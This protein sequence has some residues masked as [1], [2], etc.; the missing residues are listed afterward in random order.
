MSI[1]I[2]MSASIAIHRAKHAFLIHHLGTDPLNV[3][4]HRTRDTGHRNN[5]SHWAYVVSQWQMNL[6]SIICWVQSSPCSMFNWN[7]VI[8]DAQSLIEFELSVFFFF[9]PFSD[10]HS[11]VGSRRFSFIGYMHSIILN[12][13]RESDEQKY[14]DCFTS[15]RAIANKIM[16]RKIWKTKLLI[17]QSDVDLD[18]DLA[19]DVI[20]NLLT[21]QTSHFSFSFRFFRLTW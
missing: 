8:F 19:N 11:F 16:S 17:S 12:I 7:K 15:D 6:N 13:H 14:L 21:V 1:S 10:C 4:S 5:M 3:L 18:Y 2:I 20:D 9:F